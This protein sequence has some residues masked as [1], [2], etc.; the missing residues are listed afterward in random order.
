MLTLAAQEAD[1]VSII[2]QSAKAGGLHFGR[3][4]DALDREKV[5]WV[6]EAAG[7]ASQT[8]VVTRMS[9]AEAVGAAPGGSLPALWSC[10][11]RVRLTGG[12]SPLCKALRGS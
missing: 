9:P 11:V 5:G 4:T 3:E 7:H 10:Q 6:R 8:R 2:A 12:G 1:I